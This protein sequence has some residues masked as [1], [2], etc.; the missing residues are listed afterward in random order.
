MI[1]AEVD[2][3]VTSSCVKRSPHPFSFQHPEKNVSLIPWRIKTSKK[4]LGFNNHGPHV[5]AIKNAPPPDICYGYGIRN[6]FYSQNL[7]ICWVETSLCCSAHTA[8]FLKK[9]R[10]IQSF[11][12]T[13][14][15]LVQVLNNVMDMM[16]FFILQKKTNR[17]FLSHLSWLIH[18]CKSSTFLS[19]RG[20]EGRPPATR[21]H[22]QS[23]SV[24]GNI[25]RQWIVVERDVSR[26]LTCPTFG[27]ENPLQRCVFPTQRH[28][29]LILFTTSGTIKGFMYATR[30]TAIKRSKECQKHLNLSWN[31][32][33]KTWIFRTDFRI[34]QKNKICVKGKQK[35]MQG[36]FKKWTYLHYT[37]IFYLYNIYIYRKMYWYVLH[38]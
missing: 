33:R 9:W 25:N 8:D 29:H 11:A 30:P 5:P 3:A 28:C 7:Q 36:V 17:L 23:G 10:K 14:P 31:R 6:G 1:T 2:S 4:V 26:E 37:S 24:P 38:T 16:S 20:Y 21:L 34:C 15:F 18:T 35:N 32:L 22:H 12:L 13:N 19:P 27:K